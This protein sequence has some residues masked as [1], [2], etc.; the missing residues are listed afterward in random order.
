MIVLN[1]TQ[2]GIYNDFA[3]WYIYF[4]GSDGIVVKN[5]TQ[6]ATVSNMTNQTTGGEANATANETNAQANAT[7]GGRRRLQTPTL[8]SA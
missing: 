1:L 6:N 8:I 3:L 2:R 7:N 5:F 4:F